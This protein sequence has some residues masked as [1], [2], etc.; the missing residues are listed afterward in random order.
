MRRV[1][2]WIE[3]HKLPVHKCKEGLPTANPQTE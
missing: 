3:Q 1:V 2:F